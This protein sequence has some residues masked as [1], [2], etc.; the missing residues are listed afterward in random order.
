MDALSGTTMTALGTLLLRVIGAG[1]VLLIGWLVSKWL[2]RLVLKLLHRLDLDNR[3]EKSAGDEGVPQVEEILSKI[4]YYILMLFVLV[5]VFE[6]LGLTIITE[7]LNA[8]LATI[9]AYMPL[10]I[11]G[12]VLIVAAW[13]VAV[14]L[15]GL[16]R[17]LLEGA[18]IDKRVGDETG[19][20]SNSVS[21]AVSEAVYWLVWLIFLPAILG[22]FGLQSLVAPLTNMWVEIL[23]YIPQLI[24]AAVIFVV[25]YFVARIVRRIV[26]SFL[27]AIGTDDFSDR[28][29]LGK[30]LGKQNLSGLLGLITFILILIPI[31][32]AGLEALGFE[33]LT[34]PLSAMLETTFTAIPAIL[35]AALILIVAYVIGKLLGELVASVLEGV[36]FDNILMT[37]GL[38]KESNTGRMTPS[39][40]VGYLVM[41]GVVYL[42][43]LSASSMLELPALTLVLTG[44]F[45]FAV[46]ILVGLVIFGLGLWLAGLLVKVVDA[47][48][49]PQK[50]LASIFVRVV[51]IALAT[52]MALSQMGLA[53]SII[54]MAFGLTLGAAAL[55]VAL[56]FG[57]GG[58]EVAGRE[59]E[60]W[61]GV[62]HDEGIQ[63]LSDS[64]E[65]PE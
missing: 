63:E 8:L 27:V 65:S 49:W 6:I 58:R 33:A 22:A 30:M 62:L 24:A 38:T 61:V 3:M 15:R 23:A 55:A 4:V 40:I 35:A 57:L 17:R 54:N 50:N 52:A 11:A 42:A 16:T 7:P 51:V 10:F 26:V 19:A 1:I 14:I 43:A 25:G 5:A 20:D 36:G 31:I 47:S 60:G 48:D 56:A 32:I 9:G 37:L 34:A 45:A 41:I 64:A 53:D 13:I 46:R 44:F 28:I 12:V 29:G 39:Q 18:G 2:A 59:L 21:K